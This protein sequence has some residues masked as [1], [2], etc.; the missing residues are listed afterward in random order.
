MNC[1]SVFQ[2]PSPHMVDSLFRFTVPLL[3]SDCSKIRDAIIIGLGRTSPSS[4]RDF[5][6]EIH[7]LCREA[8]DRR[9]EVSETFY[10]TRYPT[11]VKRNKRIVFFCYSPSE[12]EEREMP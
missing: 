11:S 7:F 5:I 9:A 12:K 8:L 10:H 3:K 2:P 1:Y 4:Y 6:E